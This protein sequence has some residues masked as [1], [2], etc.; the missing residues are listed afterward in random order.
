MPRRLIVLISL[1]VALLA[2]LA[3]LASCSSGAKP[4]PKAA[5]PTLITPVQDLATPPASAS[6][7]AITPS[8]TPT[9]ASAPPVLPPPAPLPSVMMGI[10]VLEA[11]GFK[12]IAGKKIALLTHAAGVNR[13]GESTISVLRR[14]PNT[15]LVCLFAPEHGLDGLTKA[16]TNFGDTIH[17][18]SG[19]PVYSLYGKFKKPTPAMLKGI[20][21]VLIDL[22][23][24]GVRSY[25][26]VSWMRYMLEACF[27]NNVEAIVLDRPNP[28]GGLKVGGAPLDA[29][30]MSDVGAFRVPYVHGLT[31][32]ELA[33]MAKQAPRVLAVTERVRT[34]GKL[35]VIPMRGWTRTMRWPETGLRWV[36]T[37]P[38]VQSFDAAL[39]YAAV[40]LG[41]QNNQ[42]SSGIGKEFPFRGISYPKKT[43]DEIIKALEAYQ[44][45]GMAFLKRAGVKA[46]GTV[47]VGVYVEIS[48]WEQW[49]PVE[50]CFIMHLQAVKWEKQNPYAKLTQTEQRTFQIHE[51]STAWYDALARDGSRA[52]LNAFLKNWRDRAAVYQQQSKKYWL[53]P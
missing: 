35:T 9:P 1:G 18:A 16:A 24:V 19:L 45:P 30:W 32:G 43:P 22:Q 20:D 52:N 8:P 50:L 28:L 42:W 7:T 12:E 36:A 47:A 48:D 37:S 26:F 46:D 38:M 25:T 41:T 53:Y 15:K 39:G 31:I 33:T 14:A 11:N 23:D 5:G 40:S 6:T 44:L 13:R 49:R 51:G 34:A 27:D 10:D 21:A 29:E 4:A 2:S 3:T 17:A